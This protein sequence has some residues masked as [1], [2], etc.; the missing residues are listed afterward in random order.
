MLPE[1]EKLAAAAITYGELYERANET[2][3]MKDRIKLAHAEVDL[4]WAALAVHAVQKKGK[5]N[6][7]R[8]SKKSK[9]ESGMA[10][11]VPA[12]PRRG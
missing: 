2:S 5:P 3:D 6:A 10:R 12:A 7:K 1:Y 8:K 9:S 11:L 4:G